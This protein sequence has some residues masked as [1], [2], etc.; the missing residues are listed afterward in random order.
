MDR[1]E[2]VLKCG[3]LLKIAKPHLVSCELKFGQDIPVKESSKSYERYNKDY[4]YVVITC[5]NG[6]RY[7]RPVDGNDLIA[8]A[9]EIFRS[10][11]HK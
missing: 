11:A 7:V 8:I 3:E 5:K 1:A 6:K 9:E 10:M 2:F 4:E